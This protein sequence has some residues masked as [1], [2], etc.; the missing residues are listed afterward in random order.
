[1][2]EVS[3][4]SKKRAPRRRLGAVTALVALVVVTV[5]GLSAPSGAQYNEH[6]T[7]RITPTTVAPGG[8][9]T[10]VAEGFLPGSTVV[11]GI[12]ETRASRAPVGQATAD[13]QGTAT[14]EITLPSGL[15]DGSYT[16]TC[17]GLDAE[18]A[19]VEVGSVVRVDSGTAGNGGGDDDGG[20]GSDDLARTGSNSGALARIA[21]LLVA[22]G[23]ALLLLGKKRS[24]RGSTTA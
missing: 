6:P 23:A 13:S 15:A 5:L 11:F 8:T 17:S 4:S 2:N 7:C 19:Q 3:S 22:G 1:V 14:A 16:I 18:G 10:V 21:V 20:P 9:V 12:E 24:Q